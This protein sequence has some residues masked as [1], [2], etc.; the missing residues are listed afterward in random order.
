MSKRSPSL[1]LLT[2]KSGVVLV[3]SGNRWVQRMLEFDPNCGQLICG[4]SVFLVNLSK[5]IVKPSPLRLVQIPDSL[6]LHLFDGETVDIHFTALSRT[7]VLE[8]SYFFQQTLSH[9]DP[10][11]D[12]N[13]EFASLLARPSGSLIVDKFQIP[14]YTKTLHCLKRG[15]WLSDE[16]INFYF[17]LIVEKSKNFFTWSTFFWAKLCIN[18]TYNYNGVANWAKKRG[19]TF[20]EIHKVLIPLHVDKSHWAL[21]IVDLHAKTSLYLDP[22]GPHIDMPI[23]HKFI[24]D[25]FATQLDGATHTETTHTHDLLTRIAPP[26]SLPQQHNGSDCGVLICMYARAIVEGTDIA[27][28][29]VSKSDIANMR[30]Q[31]AI[32]IANSNTHERSE[33]G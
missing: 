16:I 5:L 4:E 3:K 25:Y 6:V 18:E 12:K 29:V 28:L 20:H 24:N 31:I 19:V 2:H 30:K 17:Q 23:F 7:S 11:N 22:L 27:D 8:W 9:N 32:E 13:S 33:C 1:D 15:E 26:A 21:G 10:P 14:I